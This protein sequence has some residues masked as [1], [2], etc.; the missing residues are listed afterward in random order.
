MPDGT[1]TIDEHP[2]P[3]AIKRDGEH[4]FEGART[5]A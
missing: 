4:H 3:M 1:A 5:L 2:F